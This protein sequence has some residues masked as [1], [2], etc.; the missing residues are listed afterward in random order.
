MH[1]KR[2]QLIISGRVQGVFYRVN[3]QQ[4]AQQLHLV[5]WVR[6]CTDGTVETEAQGTEENITEFTNWCKEGPQFAKVQSVKTQELDQ[7]TD[8]TSFEIRH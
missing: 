7:L 5:G 2:I 8:E 6:N 1:N 3:T 4:K